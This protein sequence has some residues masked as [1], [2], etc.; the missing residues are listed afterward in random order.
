MIF[1]WVP[2]AASIRAGDK[3]DDIWVICDPAPTHTRY[4]VAV[5]CSLQEESEREGVVDGESSVKRAH[6][7]SCRY[8]AYDGRAL[9]GERSR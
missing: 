1:T 7:S 5:G 6:I 3:V 2:F 8:E 4:Q 9:R